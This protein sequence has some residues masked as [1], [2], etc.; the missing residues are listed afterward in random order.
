MPDS[1]VARTAVGLHV[2]KNFSELSEERINEIYDFIAYHSIKKNIFFTKKTPAL[3]QSIES[4]AQ[5]MCWNNEFKYSPFLDALRKAFPEIN[6][7]SGYGL[8]SLIST[9]EE[10][11]YRSLEKLEN[12]AP[13]ACCMFDGQSYRTIGDVASPISLSEELRL[14]AAELNITD[15]TLL[16]YLYALQLIE[17]AFSA[18]EFAH[19]LGIQPQASRKIFSMLMDKNIIQIVG[20]RPAAS[21]GRPEV[22]YCLTERVSDVL[23][24]LPGK[25]SGVRPGI[26]G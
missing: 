23:P 12:S 17:S 2:I 5:F 24:A 6:I 18:K 16:R 14:I 11:A 20:K 13:F 15:V 21:K 7:C 10:W 4:Y 26:Q 8:A 3:F 22:L 19:A 9:A 25:G 1:E